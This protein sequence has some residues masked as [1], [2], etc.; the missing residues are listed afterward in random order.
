MLGLILLLL[1]IFW[2]MGYGPLEALR[3]HL[4]SFAGRSINLW[5]V[6]IFLLIIWL[7]DALPGPI[8]SIVVIALIIWLL[9]VFGIIAIPIFSNLV[10]IAV[11]IGL[12]LYL[13]SGR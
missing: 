5:D 1:I 3:I 2:F 11:I 7:I 10:I 13:I 9:G 4:F 6:L 12:G 8:R